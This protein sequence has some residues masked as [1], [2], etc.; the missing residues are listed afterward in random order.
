MIALLFYYVMSTY[1][2]K[3]V[4]DV[5][6]PRERLVT[7]PPKASIKDAALEMIE[8]DVGSVLVTEENKLLGILTER[9]IVRCV[10]ENIPFSEKLENVMTK[11]LI[12]IG[13]NKPLSKAAYLMSENNIRHIPVVNLDKD[14]VG[15][16]S[17]RDIARFYAEIVE[18]S[19]YIE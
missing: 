11:S 19:E 8:K 5:M 12:T 6:T 18:S 17:A 14:L 13:E 1:V 4:K 9:D 16:I 10:S 2:G 3:R 7:L 15:I